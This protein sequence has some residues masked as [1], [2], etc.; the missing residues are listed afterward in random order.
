MAPLPE[1]LSGIAYLKITTKEIPLIVLILISF[2]GEKRHL[3]IVINLH[4]RCLNSLAAYF[5]HW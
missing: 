4:I 3:E 1:C 2:I 5:L